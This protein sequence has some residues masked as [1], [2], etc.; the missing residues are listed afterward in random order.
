MDYQ[1]GCHGSHLEFL[2]GIIFATFDLHV[3]PILPT[4]VQ[5][6]WLF[7]LGEAQNRFSRWWPWP[8]SWISNQNDFS[9]FYT[10]PHNSGGVL[11][12]YVAR[13]CVCPSRPSVRFSFPDDNLSKPQWIFTKLGTCIDIVEI[14][15]GIANR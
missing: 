7:G 5:V 6:N 9:Y 12:F 11:W 8:P 4:K 13:P 2:I 10:P 1:D 15:F 3:A 14:W